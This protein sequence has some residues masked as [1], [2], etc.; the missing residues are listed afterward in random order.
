M[1]M[2]KV[3]DDTS[4][5][6]FTFLLYFEALIVHVKAMLVKVIKI[7]DMVDTTGNIRLTAING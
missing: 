4:S 2:H 3:F 1:H 5:L 6:Y 7:T